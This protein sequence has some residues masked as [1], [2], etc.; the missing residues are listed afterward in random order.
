MTSIREIIEK[1]IEKEM[2]VK[3][4]AHVSFAELITPAFIGGIIIGVILGIPGLNLLFPLVAI[5][6]YYAVALV[7]EYYEKYIT[8]R[9]A[10]KVGVVAGTIGAFIGA[11]IMLI[12]VVFYGDSAAMF[13]RS[14]LD[15]STANTVLTFSGLDPYISLGTL[16]L[17][18][19]ANLVVG[20]VMGGIGGWYYIRRK[21]GKK[22]E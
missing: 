12:V 7:R 21:F 5:G 16:G 2:K 10:I 11:L 6:G 20:I 8:E 15:M 14:F 9:D 22:I 1:G 13:F 18:L 19:V 3:R 4:D 17:R